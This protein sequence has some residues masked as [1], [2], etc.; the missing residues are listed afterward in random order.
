MATVPTVPTVVDDSIFDDEP[1]DEST[2]ST[3]GLD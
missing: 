1:G 3:Y 2:K